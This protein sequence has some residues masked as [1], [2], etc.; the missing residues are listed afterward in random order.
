[1]SDFLPHPFWNFSLEVYGGDGAARACLDLQERRGADVNL[2]LYCTWLGASGRGTVT[3]EKLRVVIADISRWQTEIVFSVRTRAQVVLLLGHHCPEHLHANRRR[4]LAESTLDLVGDSEG[5]NRPRAGEHRVRAVVRD[6]RQIRGRRERG[7]WDV[8]IDGPPLA[9]MVV[10]I[11]AEHTL[12]VTKSVRVITA[13]RVEKQSGRVDRSASDNERATRDS[14]SRVRGL[15]VV[16]RSNDLFLGAIPLEAE[17]SRASDE[18]EPSLLVC[19]LE[20]NG[21]AV[22]RSSTTHQQEWRT[23]GE[24]HRRK[25]LTV[26]GGRLSDRLPILGEL[27]AIV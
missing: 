15:V 2:L 1:M 19:V 23:I 14:L 20:Q 9:R 7:D 4:L 10:Q 6:A 13:S 16:D 24:W 5:P 26:R 22:E 18:I 21:V 8:D 27:V 3:V 25:A 12:A 17:R 11:L